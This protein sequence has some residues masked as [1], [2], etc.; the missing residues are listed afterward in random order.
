MSA[1]PFSRERLDA[2][3]FD[4]DGVLTATAKVHAACWKKMFDDFLRRRAESSAEPFVPF[5]IDSDYKRYVDGKP[6]YDGVSSF[7]DSRGIWLPYGDPEDPVDRETVCGLGNRKS[8]M[9]VDALETEGVESYEGSVALVKLLR[10]DGFK[11]A[12]VSSS[13]NCEAVLNAAGI[14]ELFDVRVDGLVAGRLSLPGKPAPDTFIE[15]AKELGV[16][17]ARAAVVED[18]IAGVEA[19]RDGGFGLVI[20]VAREGDPRA[21]REHGAHIVVSDLGELLP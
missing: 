6:R 2:V 7:L 20:G 12:V 17:P 1:Y 16:E 10:R 9:V 8:E 4:L 11:T 14:A 13:N 19:G 15:A 18:A 5:D 3:L 21:L